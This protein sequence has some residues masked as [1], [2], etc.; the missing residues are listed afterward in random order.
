MGSTQNWPIVTSQQIRRT[1][2]LAVEE[3]LEIRLT[4]GPIADRRRTVLTVTMRTPG[5]DRELALGYLAAEGIV[6]QRDEVLE[7]TED[8]DN[9]IRIALHPDV[10]FNPDQHV[11][12][13]YTTS[14]CGVC[15]KR[16]I[17][18]VMGS[19]E[20]MPTGGW[21]VS[22]SMISSLPEAVRASQ[23][24]FTQTGGLHAAA[25]FQQTGELMTVREDVG[26]HNA[27]DKVL[28]VQ[29]EAGN[30]PLARA[31]LFVSGRAS[32]EL[33]QKAV[34]AGIPMLAAVGAPSSLAV[35]L[36][37]EAGLTLCGF[38][39]DQRFNVYTH[40]ERFVFNRVTSSS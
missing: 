20:A 2:S 40:P 11:R 25:L 16:S 36:A 18:Q 26:R 19:V 35:Q 33:V 15:G 12:T 28:G 21:K 10:H 4:Y 29:F 14:S 8:R 38:V 23:Q 7:L 22:A 31:V 24:L 27:V 17:E 39:R 5:Q 32:F 30:W 9:E 6:R 1:D 13:G 34:A 37:N 3:P